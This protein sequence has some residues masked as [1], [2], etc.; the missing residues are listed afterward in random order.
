MQDHTCQPN[1]ATVRQLCNLVAPSEEKII[2]R[3]GR[4][5]GHGR[6]TCQRLPPAGSSPPPHGDRHQRHEGRPLRSQ[7]LRHL[8]FEGLS[9]GKSKSPLFFYAVRT[10]DFLVFLMKFMH[11]KSFTPQ[12]LGDLYYTIYVKLKKHIREK[13]GWPRSTLGEVHVNAQRATVQMPLLVNF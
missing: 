10:R 8:S 3:Q 2:V 5:V 13:E 12:R 1:P 11:R 9:K 6:P 4:P 7:C